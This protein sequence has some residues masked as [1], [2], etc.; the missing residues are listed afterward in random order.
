MHRSLFI[1]CF[2]NETQDCPCD[3]NG[4]LMENLMKMLRASMLKGS[5]PQLNCPKI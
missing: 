4:E 5:D 1:N 3:A 2:V